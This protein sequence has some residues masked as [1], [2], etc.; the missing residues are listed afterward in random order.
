MPDWDENSPQL[1]ANLTAVLEAVRASARKRERPTLLLARQWHRRTMEGL[2]VKPAQAVGRFRGETGL[3]KAQVRIG[4]RFGVPPDGV[5]PALLRFIAV[6]QEATERL[7]ARVKSSATLTGA[8]L[9]DILDLCAWAHAE[10]VR[11]HPFVNGNGRSARL[12]AN[13]IAMRYGLPPFV[14][15]RPRPNHGY[16]PAGA[17]AMVGDWRPTAIVFRT[18]LRDVLAG[19]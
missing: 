8:L 4:P 15:L 12:W 10:W 1:A 6:L 13:F 16:G 3:E 19:R 14:R 11:I 7:D 17:R 9:G 18:M 5:R 2:T